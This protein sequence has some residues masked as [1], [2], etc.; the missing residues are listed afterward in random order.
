MQLIVSQKIC[1]GEEQ[2][3]GACHF[4]LCLNSTNSIIV[5]ELVQLLKCKHIDCRH[6][7]KESYSEPKR[8]P[9]FPAL[10][11]QSLWRQRIVFFFDHLIDQV[12]VKVHLVILP[13]LR[14]SLVSSN[15]PPIRLNLDSLIEVRDKTAH[16]I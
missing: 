15:H 9:N 16:F 14:G 13:N 11:F 1:M 6:E 5:K 10:A 4:Q 3:L 12:T 2:S 7:G 8:S